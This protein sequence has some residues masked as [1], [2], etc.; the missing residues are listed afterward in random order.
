MA[1]ARVTPQGGYDLVSDDEKTSL[2][3]LSRSGPRVVHQAPAA[4]FD[5][6]DETVTFS[7]GGNSPEAASRVVLQFRV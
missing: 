5:V 3:P 6:A 7:F 4:D 2:S 1:E